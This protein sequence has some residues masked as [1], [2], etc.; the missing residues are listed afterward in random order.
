MIIMMSG[1]PEIAPPLT[2]PICSRA[3]LYSAT[4]T[5]DTDTRFITVE[6]EGLGETRVPHVATTSSAEA[7]ISPRSNFVA[8]R[9]LRASQTISPVNIT[10]TRSS[11]TPFVS[12]ID[13]ARKASVAGA[14]F[15]HL[16]TN[17]IDCPAANRCTQ[18]QAIA[19]IA[20]DLHFGNKQ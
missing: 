20:R 15:E 8:K 19:E 2:E 12:P 9:L 1:F 17:C 16:A 6:I 3:E 13:V 11:D 14:L 10:E 4:K 18:R 7:I 5:V